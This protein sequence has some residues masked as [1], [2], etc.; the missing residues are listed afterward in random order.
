MG[1]SKLPYN[2]LYKYY[3]AFLLV[4]DNVEF[5]YHWLQIGS[6]TLGIYVRHWQSIPGFVKL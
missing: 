6:I 3:M 1:I 2:L 5:E 4:T